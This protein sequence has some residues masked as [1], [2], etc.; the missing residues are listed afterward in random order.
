M[1]TQ[2][3]V[4][5]GLFH[6]SSVL[7]ADYI[8]PSKLD[9]LEDLLGLIDGYVKEGFADGVL[10]CAFGNNQPGRQNAAEWI[11]TA[12]HDMSTHD[13]ATGTG[14]LDA[15]IMFELDRDENVGDAF[16]NTFG[17]LS[18]FHNIR[19]SAADLIAL[20]AVAATD[21]CNGPKV[22]FRAG[23]IDATEAGISGV[24]KPDETIETHTSRF[25]TAGFNTSDMIA[26][27]ACG[28]TVGGVHNDDFP[29]ITGDTNASTTHFFEEETT[30]SSN[31]FDNV[32]VTGY[33]DGSTEN[34]LAVGSNDTTN[35]D[36]RVF[37]ADGNKTMNALADP[38]VFQSTCADI[39]GR[40]IDTVPST[41]TLSDPIQPV[42][43]KPYIQKFALNSNGTL[44]FQ[45]RVRVR[46]S[47]DTG[48]NN[49]DLEV[50]LTY[51]DRTG[52]NT[53][54]VIATTKLT[55]KLGTSSGFFGEQFK[56]FE[57]ETTLDTAESISKFHIHLETPSTGAV[58]LFDNGG[59]GF[60][61]DDSV[62]FQGPQSCLVT[63]SGPD[64]QGTLTISAAVRKDRATEPLVLD[65]V[66]K[67]P[68]QGVVIDALDVRPE[69]FTAAGAEKGAYVL[70]NIDVPL[71][72]SSWSTTFDLVLGSGET[73]S[74][75]DFLS[76]GSLISQSCTPL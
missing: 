17:F 37:N 18:G 5:L 76:T 40:M 69:T 13:I 3:L 64:Y 73:E 10:T 44:D 21:R 67:V 52:A 34:P 28:H 62:L 36:K 1:K 4:G 74:R 22:A 32:V 33:L 55:Y 2:A 61:I 41:V 48:R 23:R 26:M 39:L 68:R 75:A 11:R 63:T 29:E 9:Y 16:N 56:W 54:T 14:G 15:S 42:D 35:S 60:P 45:G 20:A 51:A 46:T 59:N 38:E 27:V 7:A 65:L 31:L 47:K 57:F 49:D 71:E 24:P 19:A 58:E 53:S 8:W 72:V 66:H 43:V 6:A 30:D 50:H 12:Y 25:A 70:F